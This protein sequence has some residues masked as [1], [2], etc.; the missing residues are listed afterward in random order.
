MGSGLGRLNCDANQGAV[1]LIDGRVYGVCIYT[2][3]LE[4]YGLPLLGV[5]SRHICTEKV[6]IFC[7]TDMIC[8]TIELIDLKYFK[9]LR[10]IHELENDF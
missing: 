1:S 2:Y 5:L 8:S 7:S 4:L 3:S 9:G 10:D 6:H